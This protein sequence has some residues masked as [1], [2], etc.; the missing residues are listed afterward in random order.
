MKINIKWKQKGYWLI[1]YENILENKNLDTLHVS[2]CSTLLKL[3][4]K[5]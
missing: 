1:I 5:H 2:V 3:L 4:C